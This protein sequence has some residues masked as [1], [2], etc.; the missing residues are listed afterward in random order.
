MGILGALLA[1]PSRRRSMMLIEELR[2]ELP[3]QQ[4][5]PADTGSASGDERGG[6]EYERGRRACRG[7]GRRDRRRDS[8]DRREEERR[9]PEEVGTTLAG[10]KP[11]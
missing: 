2:V 11:G 9:P 10:E 4:E 5:Q 7:G 1:L 3:G 6:E 8:D